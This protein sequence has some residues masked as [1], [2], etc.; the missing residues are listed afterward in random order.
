M[1]AHLRARVTGSGKG[2]LDNLRE[3][4]EYAEAKLRAGV[5]IHQWAT[6]DAEVMA[7]T[8][9]QGVG[10][11]SQL[12]ALLRQNETFSGPADM[13]DAFERTLVKRLGFG[14]PPPSNVRQRADG[15]LQFD[16][17]EELTM[18]FRDNGLTY[19]V[20]LTQQAREAQAVKR[21][22]L[23]KPTDAIKTLLE[24]LRFQAMKIPAVAITP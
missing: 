18:L 11:F 2:P 7:D 3:A 24:A 15:L 16:W 23:D 13:V 10:H 19:C 9:I 12:R 6:V 20:T 1:K 14:W 21:C 4:R 22:D 17:A 8:Q 5:P